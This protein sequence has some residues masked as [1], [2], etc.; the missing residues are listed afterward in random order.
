MPSGRQFAAYLWPPALAAGVFWLAW[1]EGAYGLTSRNSVAVV[2]LWAI[3]LASAAG[4]WPAARVP[5][6]AL[7]SGSLL[8]AFAI[9]VGL[10]ALWAASPEKAFNEFD[11]VLVFLAV[12]ALAVVAAP[13]G[14]VRRWLAGLALGLTAVGVIALISRLFPHSF[15]QTVQL[16]QAFPTAS[17]RLSF[18]VD[19]WNGLAT[20]VAFAIPCLLY[21]AAEGRTVVRGLAVAPLP[22]LTA[23][24]YLTSSR[25][26]WLAGAGAIVVLMALT[27]RRWATAGALLIG[28]GASIG[29]VSVLLSRDEL[30]DS[31]LTSSVAESQGR[32]AFF[33]IAGLCAV[34]GVA[35]GLLA[36]VVPSPPRASRTASTAFAAVLVLLTLAAVVAAHPVRH[37]ENFKEIP[38]ELSG[39]SVQEHLF[40]SSG[41]GRW[42]WWTSAL[43]EWQTRPAVGRGAG[44][45]EAWWA[46]HASIP[47]FVRDAHSL[48]LETLGELGIVGLALL[49]AFF[50]SC[51]VAGARRLGGREDDERAAVATLL[52]LVAAFL[53]EAGIDW[54]W[55]LT[56]VSAIAMLALGLLTGPATEPAFTGLQAVETRRPTSP[57][58]RVAVAAVAF[59]LIVAE[60]IPLLSTM[61]VR[62][63]QEAVT[64]GN[65]PEA[66]DRAKSARSIQPWAASPYLQL[67]LVQEL[68]GQI[69]QAQGSI[70]NALEKDDSD[71]RLWL[72]AA[73][74]QTKS[75]DIAAA[76]Q[77]LA[78]A[79]ELNPKSQLFA[80]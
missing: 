2:V 3:V 59:G 64:T 32:S 67:A 61:E 17:K 65:L 31:P 74:I 54:M 58:L 47:V 23:T 1:D 37:Y 40:S 53:F 44:S 56:A 14:S 43:D 34:A 30:V 60:A 4:L 62:R 28:G 13:R 72:V 77:S 78:K 19:Y 33:L 76:R 68:G 25:G 9:W 29:A 16:A 42:Q 22:A 21:F 39:A 70:E 10:S 15:E 11:R 63:S 57:I 24:L 35:Y 36:T 26:G 75:G 80:G 55:E 51:L 49:L 8:G 45:Y 38:P 7:V 6:A 12:F 66:L 73:R 69:D 79:R 41:N 50:V 18:P 5:R 46:E 27:S 52:A 71:W 48:Y 20:L